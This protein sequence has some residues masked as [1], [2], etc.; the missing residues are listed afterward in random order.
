[1]FE[2]KSGTLSGDRKTFEIEKK[3]YHEIDS[4]YTS[5]LDA[6][7]TD[8]GF[9]TGSTINVRVKSPGSYGVGGI[10]PGLAGKTI[11]FTGW[12]SASNS[13][14]TLVHE[15]TH[16]FGLAHKCGNWDFKTT[17]PST[18]CTMN[19]GTWFIL[20]DGTPRAP[21]PWTD[22]RTAPNLC[23]P[24]IKAI[25]ESNLEDLPGLGW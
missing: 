17:T 8:Y 19:Y 13:L 5:F 7:L 14:G 12:V 3:D 25:R 20:D 22:K 6:D 24:H 1:M 10:S 11:V 16:A 18:S 21:A 23:A 15:L 9:S 4:P 2:V